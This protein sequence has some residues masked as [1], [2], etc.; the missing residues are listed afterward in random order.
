MVFKAQ[1]NDSITSSIETSSENSEKDEID[2]GIVH[3]FQLMLCTSFNES[4]NLYAFKPIHN[5]ELP[6]LRPP[7]TA[8][9]FR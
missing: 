6:E 9:I 8:Q 4:V 5:F 2:E 7:R 3:C 1:K